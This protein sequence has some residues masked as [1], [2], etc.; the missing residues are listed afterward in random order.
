MFKHT[1][2][3]LVLLAGASI[4]ST[5]T[6][7]AGIEVSGFGGG[8]TF[9]DGG[10]THGIGGAAAAV[11]LG[12]NLHVFGE[13]AFSTL[14]TASASEAGI[15]ANGTDNLL[16]FGGGV[17]YSFGSSG[18][19]LR[20]YVTAAF[21]LGHQIASAS[22][23]AAGYAINISQTANSLY[24]GFGGGVRLYLG[25]SWGLKPEVR[26]QRYT[27]VGSSAGTGSNSVQYTV[28]LFYQFGH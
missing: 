2:R 11:S 9:D 24:T 25:K 10:G 5:I 27:G 4:F 26:Y 19:K 16:N 13:F 15:T 22:A 7:A 18:S 8:V 6:W 28:G 3:G 12:D 17:D 21:G 23:N 1:L 20:P 14:A